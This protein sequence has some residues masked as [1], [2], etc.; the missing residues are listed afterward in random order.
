MSL[1]NSTINNDN[2]Q[3]VGFSVDNEDFG[4][5]ILKVQEIIRM[6][7]ITKMPNAPEY[8][9]GVINLR[10]KVIPVIDFRKRFHLAEDE[11]QNSANKRIVVVSLD[12]MTIGIVVDKVSQVLRL[13][14]E[15]ISPTPDTVKG[16]D[17]EAISGVGQLDEKLMILL[18]LEKMFSRGE[19]EAIDKAA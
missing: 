14:N 11:A 1:E 13:P 6:V 18:D 10:G 5:D 15:H 3:L 12:H 9:E 16:F 19:F 4:V 17:A 7:E 2:I 8:V